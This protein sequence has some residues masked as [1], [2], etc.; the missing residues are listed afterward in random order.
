MD[1]WR[2]LA[3]DPGR[4]NSVQ[5]MAEKGVLESVISVFYWIPSL[6][7]EGTLQVHVLCSCVSTLVSL[8]MSHSHTGMG[9]GLSVSGVI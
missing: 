7:S 2:P 5:V 4:I 3:A 6:L 1:I 9:R 8:C